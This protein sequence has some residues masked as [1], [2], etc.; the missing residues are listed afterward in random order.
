MLLRP[1]G[2][3]G[4]E[5]GDAH[6][7]W[8]P[9]VDGRFDQ[10]GREEGQRDVILT[11]RMLHRSRPAMLSALAVASARSSAS[12][13][14]PRAIEAI[15]VARISARIGRAYCRSAPSGTIISRR[16]VDMVFCQSHM[17]DAI[18]CFFLRIWPPVVGQV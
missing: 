4:G 5:A 16:R 3:Q 11:F 15:R 18:V 1:F 13:R 17:K 14:R 9:A 12:Q 8:Q 7:L 2:R 10:I 6:S